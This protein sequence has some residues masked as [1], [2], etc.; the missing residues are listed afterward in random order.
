MRDE[1]EARGESRMLRMNDHSHE[2]PGTV[3]AE[4]DGAI[5]NR[6]LKIEPEAS[7]S[8][9]KL[10]EAVL[11]AQSYGKLGK[12]ARGIVGRFLTR[13]TGFSRAQMN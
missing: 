12:G 9:Y 7:E 5:P 6:K 11:R 1:P 3:H 4:R 10:V 8:R 13:V 2:E